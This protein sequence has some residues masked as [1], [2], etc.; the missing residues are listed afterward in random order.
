MKLF[1]LVLCAITASAQSD[2]EAGRKR[3]NTRCAGCHGEDGLGGE[4]APEI[5]KGSRKRLQSDEAVRGIIAHGIPDSGMPAFDVSDSELAAL[6]A[7][8]RSRVTPLSLTAWSGDASAGERYFFGKG[9]CSNCHMIHG[10]GSIQGPDLTEAS[11]N[12][13][14]AE[15][16]TSLLRPNNRRVA[17]YQVATVELPSGMKVRGF[18][19]NESGFDLQLLGLDGKLYLLS[20]RK[21]KILARESDSLM[22][23]MRASH[24]APPEEYRDLIA[25]L[26]AA[27]EQ[28]L[29]QS[30]PAALPGAVAWNG[31]AHPA[32][33]EW[34][35]YHG[36]LSGN[37]YSELARIN[38]KNV[39]QLA[40]AWSFPAGT[41]QALETT[42]VVA[43]GI[44][45]VT[46]VN[47]VVALDARAGRKIWS[48]SRPRS[49]ELVGDAAGGINRG[50]AILDDRVFLVTDNAHLLALHRLTG[51]LI[52]DVEM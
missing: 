51:G 27:P 28:K 49:K 18:I 26:R 2:V 17:G 42:P 25:F 1:P 38:L 24:D 50:V 30:M 7:F 34:P 52:W 8:V 6:T 47:S 41:G 9:G 22:P 4:R 39:S 31:I 29:S 45:Y 43:G 5:G 36:Q 23:A 11:R 35:T 21:F 44:M 3:F 33:G 13:T 48:Y 46:G 20:E 40:S 19:R 12:L 37:R 15:V 16:E 10:R 14:A 32:A